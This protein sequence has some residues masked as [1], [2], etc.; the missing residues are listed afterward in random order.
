MSVVIGSRGS[1]LALWQANWAKAQ[2]EGA[3][4]G[5]QVEIKI[6]KTQGD[7][8]AETPLAQIGGKEVWTKEIELALL[9]GK[10]DLAVHSLKDLPTVL[11]EGLI[12]G[13]VSPREDPR[14]ALISQGDILFQDLADGA[15]IATSSLRRQAQL[16]H[17]R[18]DLN[19][20]EIRGNVDTRLRKLDTENL[21]G[22]ILAAAGLIRLGWGDRISEAIDPEICVPAPGQ[23]ALGIEV[24]DHDARMSALIEAL[25]DVET[26]HA[27]CAERGMLEALGGG[28][29]V[30]I[31]GW[32]VQDP[33]L[34]TGLVL[35]GIVATPNGQTVIREVLSD[36]ST[37][38][39]QL[40]K[41]VAAGLL[42]K[43]AGDILATLA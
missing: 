19:F 36:E 24:R 20:V 29:R 12:L 30:P 39:V 8:M 3:H 1:A 23:A 4:S 26:H 33:K 22:I 43:G 37:N 14:D 28:C 32:A 15:T 38:A 2:L 42:E 5:L 40:G 35:T 6:I 18:P 25:N 21:D 11:P 34:E 41:R 10:I 9:E 7:R 31:G 17:A 27:V 13:A 16:Q